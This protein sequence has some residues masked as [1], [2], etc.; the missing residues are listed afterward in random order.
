MR[1]QVFLVQVLAAS[2]AF[3]AAAT[4]FAGPPMAFKESWMLMGEASEQNKDVMANYAFTGTDSVG[5]G[6]HNWK[7]ED[8]VHKVEHSG[9]NYTRRL[10]RWNTPDSQANLWF[11][12]DAGNT[13]V[14]TAFAGINAGSRTGIMP[15]VQF[16]W[17]TTRLY[18]LI[19]ASTLRGNGGLQIDTYKTQVGFSFFEAQFDEWQ[20]WL[21]L[22]G[23][24]MTKLMEKSEITPFLRLIHKSLYVEVG[25]N[26]EG[27]PRVGLMKVFYF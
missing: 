19:G 5:V 2:M 7:T 12:V 9:V 4:A 6:Y 11:V 22:E 25:A 1:L 14:P 17:E 15:S 26:T 23:K 24:R 13:K 27:K 18:F 3:A 10:A 16:D 8:L 20:P 21:I